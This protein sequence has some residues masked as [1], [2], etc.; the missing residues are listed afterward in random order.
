MVGFKNG[1][2]VDDSLLL[3]SCNDFAKSVCMGLHGGWNFNLWILRQ[4]RHLTLPHPKRSRL[5][6]MQLKAQTALAQDPKKCGLY[7]FEFSNVRQAAHFVERR[8]LAWH[9]NF[10]PLLNPCH[11]KGSL[12]GFNDLLKSAT[13]KPLDVQF[14]EA[15]IYPY[16][17]ETIPHELNKLKE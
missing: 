6:F 10:T 4:I 8:H 15:H 16:E 11:A 17:P 3:R 5:H 12:L 1:Q 14:F 13:G 2:F 9:L 7:L